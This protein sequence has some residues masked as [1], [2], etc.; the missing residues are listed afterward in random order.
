MENKYILV[1][2]NISSGKST[3]AEVLGKNL[4]FNVYHEPYADNPYL[5]NFY[6][7]MK[8]WSFK[9]QVYF[10]SHHL[11]Q[12]IEIGKINGGNIIKDCSIYESVEVY[13]KNMFL[14]GNLEEKDWETYYDLYQK[15]IISIRKPDLVIKLECPLDVLMTRISSRG[16]DMESNISWSYI[17]NLDRL[18]NDWIDSLDFAPVMKINSDEGNFFDDLSIMNEVR[19]ILNR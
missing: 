14:E 12:H 2:G 18:Y 6:K 17:E 3:L 1:S 7:D 13:A 9:S 4:D 8:K 10:L 15:V 11:S 19:K 5:E 16:R